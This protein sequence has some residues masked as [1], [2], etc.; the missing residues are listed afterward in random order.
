MTADSLKHSWL[1]QYADFSDQ[2]DAIKKIRTIATAFNTNIDAVIKLDGQK[3]SE[4]IS[5][6]GLSLKELEEPKTHIDEPK[7][8]MRGIF[9]C[10]T[11]GIAEEWTADNPQIYQWMKEHIGYDRLQMGGQAGIIANLMSLFEI[12]EVIAHTASHP[13]LQAA[14]FLKNDH[15]YAFDSQG[16][17]TPAHRIDR[18]ND[19]PLIHWIIEFA[20]EETICVE[21][22]KFTCPK[23]NRFI[24]TYDPANLVLQTDPFFIKHLEQNGF[25]YLILSGFHNL[26]AKQN[27]QSIID[28]SA[29]T[30]QHLKE[31][32]PRGIVHLE[33]ASTQDKTIR[34]HIL[35][36]IAP[37]VDSI[38]LNEREMLDFIEIIDNDLYQE[39]HT[40]KISSILMYRSLQRLKKATN[41]PR[42]QLHMYGIYMTLQDKNFPITAEQSLKGMLLAS[43][44]AASKASLGA[45]TTKSDLI[46]AQD[47]PIAD[48][49]VQELSALSEFLNNPKLCR[50]GIT[51][52]CDQILTAIPTILVDKPKTL[53]GM[54]DTISSVSLIGAQ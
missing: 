19:Q 49:S 26:S 30:I 14:Q 42:I 33:L 28:R 4:L 45:L 16:N 41:A 11:Q 53:V 2:F 35:Q 24:A 31:V 29:K 51:H 22:K 27:G 54:G 50:T 9:K 23:A 3:I 32:C 52:F 1:K 25:D 36:K 43:V 6:F 34:R 39:I 40:K 7:D 15:L 44:T 5:T 21:Q 37:L 8:V 18:T 20:K 17:L 10:F 46:Y 13:N 47:M 48:A 38:G 12:P